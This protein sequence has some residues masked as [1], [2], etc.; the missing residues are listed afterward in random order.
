MCVVAF[1]L[2]PGILLAGIK[3]ALN[4][5][6]MSRETLEPL[7]NRNSYRGYD[8][9]EKSARWALKFCFSRK[10]NYM[11]PRKGFEPLPPKSGTRPST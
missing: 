3:L 10:R 4:A 5:D 1:A 7:A 8:S 6:P 11:V 9:N 2:F